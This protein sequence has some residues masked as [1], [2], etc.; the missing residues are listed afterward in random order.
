VESAAGWSG[1]QILCASGG[2]Y[3]ACDLPTFTP[4]GK[5]ALLVYPDQLPLP[6]AISFQGV[7][8]LGCPGGLVHPVVT[9]V[10]P[11]TGPAGSVSKLTVGG[12][13][14]NLGVVVDLASNANV[15]AQATPVSL[16][17]GGTALTVLLNT[18]GVAPG[19]YDVVQDGVGYT[20]GVPSPGYLPGAY[21][22]TTGP[23]APAIGSFVPDG[24]ARIL[25]TRTGLGGVNGPVP[26]G[27]VVTLK[28]AGVAG[29][30]ATGTSAVL[31]S[32]TAEQP[33]KSG[34]IIAYPDGTTRPKVTDLSFSSAQAG[35]AQVVVPVL[36]GKIDLY[37][38]SAGSTG[39]VA[40]L[41]GY[42]TTAG[43]HSLLKAVGPNRI[44]DTRTGLG[45]PKAQL[46]AGQ[47]LQLTVDSAGGVPATGVTAVNLDV[48]VW[49]P[50][51]TGALTAFADGTTRPAASQLAFAADQTTAGLISV[52]V[53]DGKVDLYNGSSGPVDLNADV[54]GYFSGKGA[55][56]QATG[57]ARALDTRTGLGGAG[58]SVLAHSAADLSLNGL[59]GWL[60]TQREVV[61][62]VTVLD[63]SASGSLSVFPD[64][65]AVPADPDLVFQA[66]KPVTVQTIIPL[67]GPTI[68]FYNDS[69]GTI[70]ILADVQGYGVSG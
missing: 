17:S 41:S 62:S 24:P 6:T 51:K 8:T 22:V 9:S 21:Q 54:T 34:T 30:P 70:Q 60:G 46:G 33:A 10:Q 40:V 66:G 59:P 28:V 18:Q 19:T 1:D 35:S 43:T 20:V 68:D 69:D 48:I 12:T 38:G 47:T 11:A 57:P 44:L 36:N 15:V 49:N 32:L 14:L 53:V 3:V 23:P 27:G 50:S 2:P 4:P 56:L 37:N 52:P 31:L 58:V 67:T 26:S 13:N 45:A 63:A 7:C 29:V 55:K 16:N 65:S 39:L 42:F 61:L 5:Y 25:D 64:G